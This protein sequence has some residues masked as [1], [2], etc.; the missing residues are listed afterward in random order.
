MTDSEYI[1][2]SGKLQILFSQYGVVAFG[3]ILFE[4]GSGAVVSGNAAID[5]AEMVCRCEVLEHALKRMA[6]E[7]FF[8]FS[9]GVLKFKT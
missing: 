5:D 6:N 7:V 8:V 9:D 1:E 2:L 3:G 4:S